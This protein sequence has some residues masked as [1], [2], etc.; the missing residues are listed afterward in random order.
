MMAVGN[1]RKVKEA[2]GGWMTC[3]V[4]V[5]SLVLV[6]LIMWGWCGVWGRGGEGMRR[7]WERVC[8]EGKF[9]ATLLLVPR[10]M[11]MLLSMLLWLVVR[12]GYHQGCSC[13]CTCQSKPVL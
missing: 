10:P 3:D 5:I 13:W 12:E 2:L 4:G 11:V 9:L 6:V 7:G 1:I 8:V